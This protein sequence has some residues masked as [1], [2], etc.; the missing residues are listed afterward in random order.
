[1]NPSLP[2]SAFELV[3]PSFCLLL[4]ASGLAK[5]VEPGVLQA[6]LFQAWSRRVPTSVIR[7][8]ASI[9][10]AAGLAAALAGRWGYGVA[11]AWFLVLLVGASAI[12]GRQRHRPALPCGCLGKSSAPIS[13]LHAVVLGAGLTVV[14]LAGAAGSPGL[15]ETLRNAPRL[16][17]VA[18]MLSL[19][20]LAYLL[21]GLLATQPTALIVRRDRSGGVTE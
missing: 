3:A 13:W 12:L 11:A 6:A 19:G 5:L 4:A 18:A 10:A 2:A 21:Y 14:G 1:M 20:A 17:D 16:L 7:A 15:A 8:F 9:E